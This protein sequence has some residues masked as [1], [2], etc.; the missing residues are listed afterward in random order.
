MLRAGAHGG[1]VYST[2]VQDVNGWIVS[3]S[4]HFVSFTP[5]QPQPLV[6]EYSW[7]TVE[8]FKLSDGWFRSTTSSLR[9]GGGQFRASLSKL[10]SNLW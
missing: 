2:R 9:G 4:I 7:L 8:A 6:L 1:V 3:I 5:E 10:S